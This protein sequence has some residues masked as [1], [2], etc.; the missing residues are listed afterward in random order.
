[1]KPNIV[2]ILVDAL[3]PKNLSLYGYPKETDKYIKKIASE[4]IVFD[5]HFSTSNSSYPSLTSIFSGQ[6]PTTHGIVHQYPNATKEEIDKLRKNKFWLPIYLKNLGYET[7][8]LTPMSM[9]FKKG[10]SYIE[11][12]KNTSNYRKF[13][14][15][16]I[17]KKI[18]LKFPNSLYTFGKKLTKRKSSVKF[19]EP[20]E[21]MELALSKIK[22]CEKPFFLFMHFEDTHFYYPNVK[23]PNVR[24]K[25]TLKKI[26]EDIKDNSQ[27]EYVKKRFFDAHAKYLEQI[28]LKCDNAIINIDKEIGKFYFSLKKQ[29]ILDNTIFII[30]ADHGDS[31]DEHGIYF[32]HAG[33]YEET[34]HVPFIIKIPGMKHKRINELTQHT[35]IAPTII[36]ILRE[37]SKVDMDGVSMMNLIKTGKPIRD[38][39]ICSDGLCKDSVAVR[40]KNKKLIIAKNSKCYL[41]GAEHSKGKEEYDLVKDPFE[42]NNIYDGES[43]LEKGYG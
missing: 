7:M 29:G 42:K 13:T 9:W 37:K 3:R 27:K 24:G 40:T 11:E 43:E 15:N 22:K 2:F 21:T 41:C 32:S 18:L 38:K 35:E 20:K 10:F 30:I 1:M 17:V 14:N 28:K 31:I 4:S 39:I 25:I 33:V 23:T 6:Y 8:A 36:D 19:P 26:L 16:K 12:E 5:L 34:I